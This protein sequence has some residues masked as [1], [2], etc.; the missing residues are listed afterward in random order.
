[1]LLLDHSD[2]LSVWVSHEVV[3]KQL[4]L[5]IE[6]QLSGAGVFVPAHM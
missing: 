3:I 1:M 4:G 5:G 6:E 2:S